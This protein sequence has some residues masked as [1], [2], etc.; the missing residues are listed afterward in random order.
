MVIVPIRRM[1]RT[2]TAIAAV[3]VFFS[4]STK[5]A[6]PE[7]PVFI[8]NQAVWLAANPPVA[9]FTLP[10]IV[11]DRSLSRYQNLIHSW[12]HRTMLYQVRNAA[13]RLLFSKELEADFVYLHKNYLLARG[14]VYEEA[15]G[16]KYQLWRYNGKQL[17]QGPSV[18]LDCFPSDVLFVD[19]G[20]VFLTGVNLEGT[21]AVVYALD[22][23][24][25]R[26]AS[27]FFTERTDSFPRLALLEHLLVLFFSAPD[28]NAGDVRLFVADISEPDT[29]AFQPLAIY[30]LSQDI[31][32]FAGYAFVAED[33]V[34]LPAILLD[35]ERNLIGIQRSDQNSGA[36][37]AFLRYAYST[38]AYP[39]VFLPIGEEADSFWYVNY[40]PL[41]KGAQRT[42]VQF[43]KNTQLHYPLN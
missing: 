6:L 25:K 2:V 13:G 26:I 42:L 24:A 15:K 16:F 33:T 14:S 10:D 9:L 27:V 31:R 30:E 22:F 4:C 41:Q 28:E 29:M 17:V 8:S 38:T 7:G 20:R 43:S 36:S 21:G 5:P 35:G 37:G 19:D 23:D 12:S 39:S 18:F 34:Y 11:R 3:A 1:L 32:A 40:D